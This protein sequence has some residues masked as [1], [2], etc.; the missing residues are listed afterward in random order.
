MKTIIPFWT[1]FLAA[2]AFQTTTQAQTRGDT[3]TS[4]SE[5]AKIQ[6]VAQQATD[7][8][9][10]ARN[11]WIVAL[12][13][14]DP[15][16]A[17]RLGFD[18]A[19]RDLAEE[20]KLQNRAE[21]AENLM[22]QWG[23]DGGVSQFETAFALGV[24]LDLGDHAP[25]FAWL[26]AFI[27]KME[28]KYGAL[29]TKL[30]MVQNVR[31]LNFALPVVFA[32]ASSRWQLV[33]QDNRIEYR[34]HFIPFVNLVTYYAALYSCNAIVVKTA[35]PQLKKL[36]KTAAQKLQFA[37]GRYVAAPISDFIFKTANRKSATRPVL[38]REQLR[39]ENGNDLIQ[40]MRMERGL[41]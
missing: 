3:R 11:Q 33:G 37:M 36:C 12:L 27:V 39:Y 23:F 25:L 15:L 9:V 21:E 20:L 18:G 24:V 35:Y 13:K 17:T 38:G 14:G 16:E 41:Q 10:R 29:I 1:L 34:K 28:D 26:E 2:F 6:L 19:V 40:E 31:M 22:R 7:A 8:S 30:P 32:P 5:R 4:A